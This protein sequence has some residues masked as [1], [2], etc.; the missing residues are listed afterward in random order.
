MTTKQKGD[1]I[2]QKLTTLRSKTG[3]TFQNIATAFLIERLVAR[4]VADQKLGDRLVFKGGFVCLRVYESP[5]YTFDLDALLRNTNIDETLSLTKVAAESDIDDGVW[6]RFESQIDLT[7]QGEYGGIR[8]SFRAGIGPVLKDLKKAQIINFDLGIGDPITPKPYKAVT[9]TLMGEEDLSWSVY[10]VETIIA[11]KLH[12]IID[13]KDAN[14]RSKDI[15][16]LAF[17]LSKADKAILQLAISKCFAH[18]QT[19]LPKNFAKTLKSLDTKI[20]K[21][22]WPSAVSSVNNAKT[23]ESTFAKVISLLEDLGL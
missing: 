20:L 1:S 21:K 14:S 4:L 23:F 10:P 6:F 16:D 17:F 12:A 5:R 9:E 22:G 7:T 15:H 18:R 8:Q 19:D 13:R 2:S 3:V 11:E